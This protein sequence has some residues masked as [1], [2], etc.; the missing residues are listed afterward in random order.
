MTNRPIL[1]VED[2]DL[3]RDAFKILLEDA[4]YRVL[5]AGTAE[6]A[7]SLAGQESPAVVILDLGLPDR[8]GLEVV[9]E[10]RGDPAFDATPIIALTGRTGY[11]EKQACL[12]AGCNRYLAK[13]VAPSALLRELTP[14]LEPS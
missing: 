3:L 11:E 1:L 4:G 2:E 10:L 14:F 9:Q 13:P 7:L 5:G 8:P 6:S 12:E